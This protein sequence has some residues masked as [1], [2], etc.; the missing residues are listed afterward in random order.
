MSYSRMIFSL[1]FEGII[2]SMARKAMEKTPERGIKHEDYTFQTG[3]N[4]K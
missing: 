3:S 1:L 4:N 2:F